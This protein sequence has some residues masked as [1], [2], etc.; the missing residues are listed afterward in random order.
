M[1]S[2]FGMRDVL[3]RGG[4]QDLTLNEYQARAAI[5]TG[6]KEGYLRLLYSAAKLS[7]EAGEV[8]E[9][10]AKAYRDDNEVIT[11]D[12]RAAILLELGDNLWY[13][14]DIALRLG[15]TLSEVADA[16]IA[17]IRSRQER[18]TMHGDGDNR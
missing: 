6:T 17:K 7:G 5:T 9:K 14:S 10:I 4:D 18:G 2:Y 12:R 8:T 16:N 1:M 15:Y 13:L 11:P 3:N